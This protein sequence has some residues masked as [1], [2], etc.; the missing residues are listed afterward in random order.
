MM[1]KDEFVHYHAI[2]RYSKVVNAY[3]REWIDEDWPKGTKLGKQDV[4]NETLIKIIADFPVCFCQFF[5]IFCKEKIELILTTASVLWRSSAVNDTDIPKVLP[6]G[7]KGSYYPS[8]IRLQY[9]AARRLAQSAQCLLLDLSYTLTR[10]SILIAYLLERH[11]SCTDT[12]ES[13]QYLLLASA[14]R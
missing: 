3:G 1:M 11:L 4:D 13:L 12:I 5:C 10:K 2:P 8:Q 14:E 6:I 7:L 9:L